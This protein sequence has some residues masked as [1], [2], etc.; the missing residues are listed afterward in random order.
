LGENSY[1]SAKIATRSKQ[2]AALGGEPW[3][4]DVQKFQKD[5]AVPNTG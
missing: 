3:S 1:K 4:S 5:L 2:V